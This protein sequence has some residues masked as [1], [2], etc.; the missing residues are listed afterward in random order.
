MYPLNVETLQALGVAR[1][2]TEVELPLYVLKRV[3]PSYLNGVR[4]YLVTDTSPSFQYLASIILQI[5]DPSKFLR[6]VNMEKKKK[7]QEK[8]FSNV[9]KYIHMHIIVPPNNL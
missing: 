3:D 2:G 1:S 4:V 8:I 7:K 5:V 9:F 6:F